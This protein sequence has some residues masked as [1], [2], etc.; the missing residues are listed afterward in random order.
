MKNP[1]GFSFTKETSAEMHFDFIHS[2]WLCVGSFK[3]EA[4]EVK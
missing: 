4:I 1:F 3:D 2:W